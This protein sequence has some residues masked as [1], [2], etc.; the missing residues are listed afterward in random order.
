MIGLFSRLSGD[1][2]KMTDRQFLDTWDTASSNKLRASRIR[3]EVIPADPK[4]KIVRPR[5]SLE[6]RQAQMAKRQYADDLTDNKP[7]PA[8]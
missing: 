5:R 7:Q 2:F 1:E 3:R 6:Y 8:Y 4:V